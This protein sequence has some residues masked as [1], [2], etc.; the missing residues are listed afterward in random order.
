M[1]AE[2]MR[3]QAFF[4][5]ARGPC[6]ASLL[7]LGL[8][9]CGGAQSPVR[10]QQEPLCAQFADLHPH[11][12]RSPGGRVERDLT[13]RATLLGA[14]TVRPGQ[15]IRLDLSLRNDSTTIS[16]PVLTLTRGESDDSHGGDPQMTLFVEWD[17]GDGTFCVPKTSPASM[18][19]GNDSADPTEP[20]IVE[21]SPGQELPLRRAWT[22]SSIVEPSREG[23]LRMFM[24]YQYSGR[25]E[26]EPETPE[27]AERLRRLCEMPPYTLVAGPIEVTIAR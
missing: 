10:E 17:R 21:L 14:S 1:A 3:M 19:C 7:S 23:R 15:P 16:Y 20:R 26:E 5:P 13:L 8:L 25:C 18:R 11:L 27:A 12:K 6:I 24:L 9:G 22:P 4:R 2:L